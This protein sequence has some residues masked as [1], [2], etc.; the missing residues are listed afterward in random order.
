MSENIPEPCEKC[1]YPFPRSRPSAR[2]AAKRDGNDSYEFIPA[3]RGT[4]KFRDENREQIRPEGLSRHSGRHAG[5]EV[6]AKHWPKGGGLVLLVRGTGPG[7]SWETVEKPCGDDLVKP[8]GYV[9]ARTSSQEE[10]PDDDFPP[11]SPD[12][13]R[14]RFFYEEARKPKGEKL[15]DSSILAKA[16]RLHPNDWNCDFSIQ[17]MQRLRDAYAEKRGLPSIGRRAYTRK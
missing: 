11:L 1:F 3:D 17:W 13:A 8:V 4:G 2:L 5:A 12:E 14:D 9:W 10:H 7:D 6:C 16:K 15:A